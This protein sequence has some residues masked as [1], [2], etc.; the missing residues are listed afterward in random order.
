VVG[1][2]LREHFIA[3]VTRTFPINVSNVK[4]SFAHAW[5]VAG[6]IASPSG[7]SSE[8][9]T[10]MPPACQTAVHQQF[11]ACLATHG[12]HR[13]VTYQPAS[14]FWT[15]QAIEA[16]IFVLLAAALLTLAYRRV[17]TADA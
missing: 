12:F 11:E 3:P 15:F 10:A 8:T 17:T 2:T 5:W 6:Y 1:L 16:G 13:V 4:G 9:G 7:Q 14:R